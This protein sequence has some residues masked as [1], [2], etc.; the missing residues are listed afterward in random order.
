MS[1]EAYAPRVGKL[2]ALLRA[3]VNIDIEHVGIAYLLLSMLWMLKHLKFL[4]A[5][6]QVI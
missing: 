3:S 1:H 5:R 6:S 2:G 4:S